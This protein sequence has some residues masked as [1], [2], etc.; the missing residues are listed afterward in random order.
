MYVRRPQFQDRQCIAGLPDRRSHLRPECSSRPLE[1]QVCSTC[2]SFGFFAEW[3]DW[4][5]TERLW[6]NWLITKTA[7][8]SPRCDMSC[9]P[10]GRSEVTL[11][12]GEEGGLKLTKRSKNT[13]VMDSFIVLSDCLSEVFSSRPNWQVSP[14]ICAF[15][16]PQIIFGNNAADSSLP[17]SVSATSSSVDVTS[18]TQ[19]QPQNKSLSSLLPVI[20]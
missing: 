4:R 14:T 6:E 10:G 16:F 7:F 19:Q 18:T 9:A 2:V 11:H 12:Q 3:F 15:I 17:Q 13:T 8:P 5:E 1:E 20:S